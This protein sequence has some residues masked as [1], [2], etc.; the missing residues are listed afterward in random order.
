MRDYEEILSECGLSK[1]RAKDMA[2][3]L[4]VAL[5]KRGLIKKIENKIVK[6]K[7]K[8]ITAVENTYGK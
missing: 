4:F 2:S 3:S 5:K 6:T 8:D 1:R 7:T